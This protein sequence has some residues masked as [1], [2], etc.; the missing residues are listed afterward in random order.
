MRA[1]LD[2]RSFAGIYMADRLVRRTVVRFLEIAAKEGTDA[3]IDAIRSDDAAVI[4]GW[5]AFAEAALRALSAGLY[6]GREDVGGERMKK[7]PK[8]TSA[9]TIDEEPMETTTNATAAAVT[10]KR[11]AHEAAVVHFAEKRKEHEGVTHELSRALARAGIDGPDYLT[12]RYPLEVRVLELQIA[13]AEAEHAVR[14]TSH[15]L[16]VARLADAA[17]RG[18]PDAA[19]LTTVVDRLRARAAQMQTAG[20]PAGLLA[21]VNQDVVEAERANEREAKRCQSAGEPPP[22]HV[23]LGHCWRTLLEVARAEHAG[24]TLTPSG[25]ATVATGYAYPLR[26]GITVGE[27][28]L[29]FTTPQAPAL[30]V[31][32]IARLRQDIEALHV[33]AFDLS[34][35]RAA[36]AE[37]EERVKREG[38]RAREHARERDARAAAERAKEQ[39]KNADAARA[40]AREIEAFV[41]QSSATSRRTL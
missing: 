39:A 23:A 11:E 41:R 35:A 20:D 19:I 18:E 30:P 10:E 36:E 29:L 24:L 40:R 28:T 37:E 32:R 33:R 34:E 17:A 7:E 27:T 2:V 9:V 13:L 12:Q 38:E 22:P 16:G 3:A 8:T 21:A 25:L 1:P 5:S 4:G 6:G 15:H 14:L 31:G 26:P